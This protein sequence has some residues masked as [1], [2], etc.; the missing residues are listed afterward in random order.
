MV[1]LGNKEQ[2]AKMVLEALMAPRAQLVQKGN[3]AQLEKW[4]HVVSW[5]QL[6]LR[7]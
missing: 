7:E 5:V 2:L 3:K 1:R 4:V 6:V